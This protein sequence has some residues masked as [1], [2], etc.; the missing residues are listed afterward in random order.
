MEKKELIN[1]FAKLNAPNPKLWAESQI[2]EGI[3]Q[4]ARYLFLKG[5]WEGVVPDNE[6]WID[7]ILQS[8]KKDNN[9]PYGGLN[10]AIRKMLECGVPKKYITEFA[11]CIAAEMIFHIGYL[12]ADS[13]S[14]KGNEYVD[15]ALVQIDN[16]GNI[17]GPISGLHESVLETDPTGNEM[18]PVNLI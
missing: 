17:I 9:L 1:I 12:I 2:E 16:E 14:V 18:R 3:P 8:N 6:V 7:N 15:W 10:I 13:S 11:R 4:L 5:A